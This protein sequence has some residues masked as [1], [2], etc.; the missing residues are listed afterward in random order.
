MKSK[1]NYS[2][3]NLII[4]IKS[5]I[6]HS[7]KKLIILMKSKTKSE[8]LDLKCFCLPEENCFCSDHRWFYSRGFVLTAAIG[9]F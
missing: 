5:K 2:F 4:V 9:M 7:F 6:N 3:K 8:S 1:I